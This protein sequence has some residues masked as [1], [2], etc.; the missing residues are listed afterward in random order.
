VKQLTTVTQRAQMIHEIVTPKRTWLKVLVLLWPPAWGRAAVRIWKWLTA[1][2]QGGALTRGLAHLRSRTSWMNGLRRIAGW[3]AFLRGLRH[4]V[5]G[6]SWRNGFSHIAVARATAWGIA[7]SRQS[8]KRGLKALALA[9]LQLLFWVVAIVLTALYFVIV[10]ILKALWALV[11]KR[12]WAKPIVG[13]A[14]FAVFA[15]SAL[16]VYAVQTGRMENPFV[17]YDG[18]IDYAFTAAEVAALTE[19]TRVVQIAWGDSATGQPILT[20]SH[21]GVVISD[22]EIMVARSAFGLQFSKQEADALN[23]ALESGQ[24]V[25]EGSLTVVGAQILPSANDRIREPEIIDLSVAPAAHETLQ[26]VSLRRGRVTLDV[27]PARFVA[28]DAP[29]LAGAKLYTVQMFEIPGTGMSEARVTEHVAEAAFN[30]FVFLSDAGLGQP[31]FVLRDGEPE[32]IGITSMQL[33]DM[34]VAGSANPHLGTF[35]QRL[36][37]ELDLSRLLA[38]AQE[39]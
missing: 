25:I 3:F 37:I 32:L 24:L 8:W 20:R 7:T 27:Q 14:V 12:S 26:L 34:V 35:F 33:D 2:W 10:L 19:S 1:K 5:S 6:A 30:N 31:L 18:E 38:E 13:I 39:Q 36:A 11:P 15:A 22:T 29:V 4:V 23:A 17:V 21:T 28:E 16:G 9:P